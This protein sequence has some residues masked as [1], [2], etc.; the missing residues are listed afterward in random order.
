MKK[1]KLVQRLMIIKTKVL[2]IINQRVDEGRL[3]VAMLEIIMM[4]MEI[5]DA[6]GHIIKINHTR[7]VEIVDVDKETTINRMIMMRKMAHIR[8]ELV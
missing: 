4:K 5:I 2:P 1:E 6:E 8:L 7:E 3:I